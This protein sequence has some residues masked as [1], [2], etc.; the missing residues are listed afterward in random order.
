MAIVQA[1]AIAKEGNYAGAWECAEKLSA[2]FPADNK[3]KQA[4][5]DFENRAADFV[6]TIRTAQTLEQQDELGASLAWLLKAKKIYPKSDLAKEGVARL[7]KKILA[8]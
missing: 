5:T 8:D 7:T 2:Q 1:N 6:Q 4:E 3:L